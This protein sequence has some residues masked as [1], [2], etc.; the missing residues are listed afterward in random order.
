MAT[1]IVRY[2]VKSDYTAKNQ[3][4]VKA[5]FEELNRHNPTGFRYASFVAEDELTHFHIAS[6]DDEI[7]NPL[8]G[9]ASFKAFQDQIADRCDE[10]PTVSRLTEVASYNLFK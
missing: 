4:L 3:T 2:K 1:V 6:I 7:E 10:Y 8:V 9:L 5:V